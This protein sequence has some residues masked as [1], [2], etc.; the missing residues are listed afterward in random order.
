[1]ISFKSYK[2]S[3]YKITNPKGYVYI[4]LTSRI[5]KRMNYYK[6]GHCSRQKKLA[7]SFDKYGFE[8]HDIIIIE[9][10][11]GGMESALDKEMFWIRSYMSNF[12]KWPEFNGLNL[13]NGGQGTIWYKA[14]D[15][16][17]KKLSELHKKNPSRGMKGKKLSE[18]TKR[19]LSEY[20]KANPSRWMLGK[21]HSEETKQKIKETKRKNNRPVIRAKPTKEETRLK[22]SLAKRGVIPWNKG[23]PMTDAQ[24]EVLSKVRLGRPSWNK[25]KKFEGTEEERKI[26]FGRHNLGNSYNKG[27]KRSPGYGEAVR[28]R[29]SGRPNIKLYKPIIQFDLIGNFLA[30]YDSIK[31]ASKECGLATCTIR[32]IAK[33]RVPNPTK[34]LF[35][36]KDA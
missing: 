10:F 12:C 2:W 3:I 29:L 24:K 27:R 28:K 31:T 33:G 16:H 7:S 13:T 30:E 4:G 26:K 23:I 17:R 14:T 19:K 32:E 15:E 25:G 20:N 11:D 5:N 21:K 6:N 36:F 34:F 22:M 8:N 1:M 9:E 35:K 18:E